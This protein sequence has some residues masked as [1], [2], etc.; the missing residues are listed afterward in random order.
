MNS[1]MK[2][3]FISAFMLSALSTGMAHAAGETQ[4]GTITITGNVVTT[5]C[6]V[7]MDKS[8]LDFGDLSRADWDAKQDNDPMSTPQKVSFTVTACPDYVKNLHVTFDNFDTT[9]DAY[10]TGTGTGT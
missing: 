3:T 5:T 4:T 1:M 2:Q 6:A 7:V 9:D 10:L 8:S